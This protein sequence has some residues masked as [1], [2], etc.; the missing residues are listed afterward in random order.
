M[1]L[2]TTD[3]LSEKAI[4]DYKLVRQAIEG[5]DRLAY[6]DLMQLYWDALYYV[7]LKKTGNPVEAEDLTIETFGKAFLKL[8]QYSPKYAF[9]TWLFSISSN[10]FID[11]A[12]RKKE[13]TLSFDGQTGDNPQINSTNFV[14]EHPDPEE[15][16]IKKEQVLMLR[17]VVERLK[18][19]Y[20]NLIELRYYQDYS[21]DEIARELDLP[22]GTVKA[23]LFRAREFLF[24]ILNGSRGKI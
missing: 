11:F 15:K 3:H 9:S 13:K 4:R 2:V 1:D 8:D 17:Q 7:M 6:A 23:K 10:N 16:F 19:H 18:P 20:R 24:N 5:G 22:S 12:R 14:S 21:I